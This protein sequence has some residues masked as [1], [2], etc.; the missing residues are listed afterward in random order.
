VAIVMGLI[1]ISCLA[2]GLGGVFDGNDKERDQ[3][4]TL[5]QVGLGLLAGA[6]SLFVLAAS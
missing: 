4:K 3:G 2:G 5:V 1:G 6:I